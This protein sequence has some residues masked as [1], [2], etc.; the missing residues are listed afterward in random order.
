MFD[1]G[2]FFTMFFICFLLVMGV[3]VVQIV[4]S[5]VRWN[6][7]NQSPRLSVKATITGKRTDVSGGARNSSAFT[8]YYVTFQVESGDRMELQV[9]STE[10][11]MMAEGDQGTLQF[12][13]TR[14]LGFNRE[15]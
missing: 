13:G 11:G 15:N 14:F 3:I 5:I 10:Y 1:E 2:L 7:N 12:Q 6:K 9:D 4:S 8:T